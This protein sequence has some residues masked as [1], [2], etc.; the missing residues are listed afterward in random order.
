ML[1]KIMAREGTLAR[2]LVLYLLWNAAG[3]LG[4]SLIYL[5]FKEAGVTVL[6]LVLSF[7]FWAIAPVLTI[8]LLDRTRGLN[9]RW[10][11]IAGI[12]VQAI[13]Y[14]LLALASPSALVLYL[15]SFLVGVNCFLFWVPF[16]ILFFE[17]CKGQEA[18]LS[19][20]YF[21]INP[22]F[23]VFL[24]VVGGFIAQSIGFPF[25]FFIALVMYA[26]V[27]PIAFFAIGNR[28]LSFSLQNSISDLKG[29]RT[30]ILV[31]GAYG[32][33]IAASVTVISLFYFTTPADLGVFL[34]ATTLV[35]L[36]ASFIVSRIS[37]AFRKRRKF[38]TY[39]GSALSLATAVAALATTAMGWASVISLRNFTSAIFY[40]FTT[41]IVLDRQRNVQKTMVAREWLLNYGRVAGIA[42]VVFS[43]IL[44]S[45]IHYSLLLLGLVILAYPVLIVRKGR[46]I[47]AD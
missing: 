13:A 45:D 26:M 33:G 34:S 19:S 43:S 15:F 42:L 20:L 32:G 35:S 16:N 25:L 11:F 12:A 27:I 41:A 44:L 5:Y 6:E 18:S 37:D 21:A 46:M 14:L 29:F 47:S 30:L 9:M 31:E 8:H 38:I 24:P 39:S 2:L 23:G 22:F 7:L 28:S 40:P 4:G 3:V 1:E 17:Q 36:I 10:I